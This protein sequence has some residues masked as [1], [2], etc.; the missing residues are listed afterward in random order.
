M[1]AADR[2]KRG[3]WDTAEDFQ[4]MVGDMA[5]STAVEDS[6]VLVSVGTVVDSQQGNLAFAVEP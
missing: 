6:E 2:M 4:D 1:V 5:G 3:I